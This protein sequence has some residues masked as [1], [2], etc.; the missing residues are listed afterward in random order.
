MPRQALGKGLDALLKQTQDVLNNPP[1]ARPEGTPHSSVQKI[2]LDKIIPNRFQPRRVF[3][4]A[5]LQE[6][7][8]AIAE[9]GLTQPIV[10]V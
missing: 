8:Q 7:A 5:K 1:A 4:E 9:H 6:L 10:V 2:A 3:D